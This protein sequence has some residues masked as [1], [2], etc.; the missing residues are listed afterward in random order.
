[1]MGAQDCMEQSE[2]RSM[3]Q[4]QMMGM[5]QQ[6]MMQAPGMG[7]PM[8]GSMMGSMPKSSGP[9]RKSKMSDAYSANLFKAKRGGKK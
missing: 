4:Q 1:M 6:Q 8:M 9:A 3:P 2:Q 7:A 5:Q